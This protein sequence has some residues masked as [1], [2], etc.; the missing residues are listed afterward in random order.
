MHG[1]SES[2]RSP[3]SPASICTNVCTH[4]TVRRGAH[5]APVHVRTPC[6]RDGIA[7][8]ATRMSLPYGMRP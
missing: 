2:A 1:R 7:L 3:S 5:G 8:R 4:T 6:R